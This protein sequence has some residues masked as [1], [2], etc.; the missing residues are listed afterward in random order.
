MSRVQPS[1]NQ[2]L[3]QNVERQTANVRKINGWI[4][5]TSNKSIICETIPYFL[6]N[7]RVDGLKGY[8]G[9]LLFSASAACKHNNLE[10]HENPF[11]FSNSQHFS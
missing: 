1:S 8:V 6:S 2:I 10:F 3:R 5:Y 9:E 11:P 7:K 4:I